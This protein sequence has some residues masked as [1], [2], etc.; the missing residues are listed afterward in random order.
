[1]DVSTISRVLW[2]RRTLRQRERWTETQLRDHQRRELAKVRALASANSAFYRRFHRGLG[3]A[4][5][6]ELPVLTKTALMDHFDEI[7][8]DPIVRLAELQ[9][10]L[11]ELHSDDLFRGRYWVS[12]TSGS[13]GRKS[14][15]ANNRQEWAMILAS[16]L[17][18]NQ[19]SGVRTGP[20]HRVKMA[21]VS[22]NT[23]WHQSS[24]VAASARSPFIASERLSAAAPLPEVVARLNKFQ[25]DILVAYGSMIRT[26]AYEQLAGQLKITPRGVNSSSEVLTG[27]ARAAATHAWN[28]APFNVYAATETGG[29]A[30]EC[31]QHRGMHLFEDLVIP[32]VVDD[33]YNPVPLGEP[34]SRLLVT[35]LFSRTVPLIR[36]E[37][38]DRLR[39]ADRLCPCGRPFRLVES[40]EGRTD[41]VIVLCAPDGGTVGVHPVVFHQ[42]LDLLDASGWQV[43]Q[44]KQGLRV[45]V[46]RPSAG[47]DQS[48]TERGVQAALAAAGAVAP[49]VHL[50]VV[51]TIPAGPAGKRPFVVAL[52]TP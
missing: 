29:I 17:R 19:W 23:P 37:M 52:P 47:F 30:A 8:T 39:L 1:M 22:S 6:G 35:V 3:D 31:D 2:L 13:S 21:V 28:I 7:S 25:P 50:L 34:G 46:A 9:V 45:L 10:Y 18:A 24:R 44:Q 26:L 20:A 48:A 14:I 49:V 36:Y 12:A 4:P 5:L 11:D 15:I 51:D 38:T 27:E 16:Y 43:S 41:D 32:E 33:D 42:V 40:I